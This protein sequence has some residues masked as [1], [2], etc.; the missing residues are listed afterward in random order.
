M[1]HIH[2][3]GHQREIESGDSIERILLS[4]DLPSNKVAVELN[5]QVIRRAHWPETEVNDGDR[6]EIVHFVGGG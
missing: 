6:I 5:G 4:L 3:N 1:I 2:L